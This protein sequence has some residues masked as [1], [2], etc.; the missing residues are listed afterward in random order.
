MGPNVI[1][2]AVA[3]SAAAPPRDRIKATAQAFEAVFVRQLMSSM[4]SSELGEDIMGSSA[5]DQFRDLAD[6]RTA[7]SM[8]AKGTFGIAD[9]LMAQLGKTA[10][11]AP[12]AIA[13]QADAPA[14]SPIAVKAEDKA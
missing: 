12:E 14:A 7:D 6:A 5:G 2:G 1:G 8:A 11:P 4:R 9:L 3:T 13:G 10:G